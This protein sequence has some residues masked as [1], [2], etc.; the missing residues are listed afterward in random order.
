MQSLGCCPYRALYWQRSEPRSASCCAC[1]GLSQCG[2]RSRAVVQSR[3]GCSRPCATYTTPSTCT[4]GQARAGRGQARAAH[5]RAQRRSYQHMPPAK[6]RTGGGSGNLHRQPNHTRS[7][8]HT[9]S[10]PT[11]P[12]RTP[13]HRTPPHSPHP[14]PPHRPALAPLQCPA[15]GRASPPRGRGRAPA[16][17]QSRHRQSAPAGEGCTGPGI[18][19]SCGALRQC[20]GQHGQQALGTASD[21]GKP[22]S[23]L[24]G[25]GA[26]Q[27]SCSGQRGSGQRQQ[28][29]RPTGSTAH[30]VAQPG[31]PMKQMPAELRRSAGASPASAARRRTSGFCRHSRHIRRSRHSG[32]GAHRRRQGQTCGRQAARGSTHSSS[33]LHNLA[34]MQAGR[35]RWPARLASPAGGPQGTAPAAAPLAGQW[36]ESRS[37]LSGG[38]PHAAAAAAP[39]SRRRSCQLA[40]DGRSA[41]W[42]LQHGQRMRRQAGR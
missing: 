28:A 31:P 14:C 9:P 11:P 16:A 18:R 17:P 10:H 20:Q 19:H 12:H 35:L 37:D 13:S 26:C 34:G 41:R 25:R 33:R 1:C 7:P 38:L 3:A 29:A 23:A 6:A 2:V 21:S 5:F 24:L 15:A 39:R 22:P 36:P 40:P 42:P 8:H 27:L 4:P 32:K 30:Q